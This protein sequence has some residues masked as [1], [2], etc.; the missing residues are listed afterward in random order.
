MMSLLV[1]LPIAGC[2]PSIRS[3]EWTSETRSPRQEQSI[4][5][6]IDYRGPRGAAIGTVVPGTY[7]IKGSYDIAN[8]SFTFGYIEFSFEGN[9]SYMQ[10]DANLDRCWGVRIYEFGVAQEGIARAKEFAHQLAAGLKEESEN[11]GA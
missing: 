11:D 6:I 8:S 9:I 7:T 3:I 5:T 2:G 4:V 1:V 10:N